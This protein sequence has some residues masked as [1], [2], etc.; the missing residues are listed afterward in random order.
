MMDLKRRG[1]VFASSA[2]RMVTM[3]N[4]YD[5]IMYIINHALMSGFTIHAFV[6]FAKWKWLVDIIRESK[7]ST[8]CAQ[9]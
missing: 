7:S 9:E 5:V 2:T 6:P 8:K 4:I 3:L 1:V